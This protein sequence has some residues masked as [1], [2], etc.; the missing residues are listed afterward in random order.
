LRREKQNRSGLQFAWK[1]GL[2]VSPARPPVRPT[3]AATALAVRTDGTAAWFIVTATRAT[4]L[5]HACDKAAAQKEFRRSDSLF[6]AT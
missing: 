2:L 6:A 1:H 5:I 3:G 4:T